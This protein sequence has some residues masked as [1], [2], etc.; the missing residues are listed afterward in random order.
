MDV[1]NTENVQRAFQSGSGKAIKLRGETLNAIEL[2]KQKELVVAKIDSVVEEEQVEK[3]APVV[4]KTPVSEEI[5]KELETEEKVE[6]V[7]LPSEKP[8]YNND[9]RNYRNT[10]LISYFDKLKSMA[11]SASSGIN[12]SSI[13][14]Q[15]IEECISIERQMNEVKESIEENKNNSISLSG[16]EKA[17]DQALGKFEEIRSSKVGELKKAESS[18]LGANAFSREWEEDNVNILRQEVERLKR[19][20]EGLKSKSTNV[21]QELVILEQE[22]NK[23]T[24]KLESLKKSLEE[25]AKVSIE[26][27][28]QAKQLDKIDE[29]KAQN[30]AKYELLNNKLDKESEDLREQIGLSYFALPKE[31]KNEDLDGMKIE[32][33]KALREEV[34]T[35][36][37]KFNEVQGQRD[38]PFVGLRGSGRRAA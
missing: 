16:E 34:T 8:L 5:T 7:E 2:R 4:E 10:S 11:K 13:Y 1:I 22:R 3:S 6:E 23:L 31:E 27:V 15:V 38:N 21:G 26:K 36:T 18:V 25:T 20:I 17:I 12:S 9:T 14:E 30:K 28:N 19:E 29:T 24:E 32:D 35:A 37:N 33:L